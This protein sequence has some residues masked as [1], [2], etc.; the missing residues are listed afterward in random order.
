MEL[1]QD[2]VQWHL[3]LAHLH[4]VLWAGML[5]ALPQLATCEMQSSTHLYSYHIAHFSK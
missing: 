1:A 5:E 3:W 2:H 4:L